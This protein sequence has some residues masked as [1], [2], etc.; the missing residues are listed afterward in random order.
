MGV[1]RTNNRAPW[2]TWISRGRLIFKINRSDDPNE[3]GTRRYKL[4]V[5]YS[6]L[7][8]R[9]VLLLRASELRNILVFRY[10]SV[11]FILLF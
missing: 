11:S 6:F 2:R 1:N 3:T 7:N 8:E 5:D 4:P 9:V 10:Y